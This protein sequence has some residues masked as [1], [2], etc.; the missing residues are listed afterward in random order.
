[1]NTK[2]ASLGCISNQSNVTSISLEYSNYMLDD[3]FDMYLDFEAF[4]DKIVPNLSKKISQKWYR[5]SMN[6]D[7]YQNEFSFGIAM[8]NRVQYIISNIIKYYFAFKRLSDNFDSII[9]PANMPEM[10]SEICMI[11]DAEKFYYNNEK[12]DECDNL[13]LL[14]DHLAEITPLPV[15]RFSKYM[16]YAEK[17]LFL[18]KKGKVIIFPDWTYNHYSH[19]NYLYQ[20]SKNI[21]NG[22][23]FKK[24]RDIKYLRDNFPNKLQT[25]NIHSEINSL[26][27]P[28]K[29]KE[30]LIEIISNQIHKE[31][32]KSIDSLCLSYSIFDELLENYKP[33]SIVTPTFHHHWHVLL[34]QI[35]RERH[36]KSYVLLD[37]Y[38]T[39]YDEN[40][41]TKDSNGID[42]LFDDYIFTGSLSKELADKY[43][44]NVKGSL[45][46]FPSST[47]NNI[48][49]KCINKKYQAM[50]LLPAPLYENPN[51]FYDQRF[52][53]VKEVLEILVD[54]NMK[55]FAI[56]I[57][58]SSNISVNND[59]MILAK[60]I[61]RY[62]KSLN[63]SI[64]QGRLYDHLPLTDIVIGQAA[65]SLIESTIYEIPFYIYEPI[66]LGMSDND[67]NRSIFVKSSYSR[68]VKELK[69]TLKMNDQTL[70]PRDKLVD[71]LNMTDILN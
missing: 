59:M 54:L 27:I 65:T 43:F 8:E 39:F 28:S 34:A 31:Y 46:V 1:M 29:D 66:Y 47:K 42:Y 38:A 56:K 51:A 68:T 67:I 35:A 32:L 55:D 23:Y 17:V 71:G 44:T 3:N 30:K 22:F 62:F 57:K 58:D 36:I 21:L 24:P 20:N 69:R 11:V 52:K 60:I 4:T 5:N 64:L 50:I 37:G 15:N 63:I 26:M 6:L 45:V 48:N 19:D 10:L 40:Y 16:R 33:K 25:I 7:V 9:I 61:N 12:S 41:Y 14:L 53:Y 70:I 49:K 2:V 18:N 13:R